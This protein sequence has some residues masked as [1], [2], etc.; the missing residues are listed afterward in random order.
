M[1]LCGRRAAASALGLALLPVAGGTVAGG[2]VAA[3]CCLRV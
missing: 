2:T 3:V 1:I